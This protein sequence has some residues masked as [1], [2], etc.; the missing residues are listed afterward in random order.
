MEK[1]INSVFV[2][3]WK[4]FVILFQL[5]FPRIC[6]QNNVNRYLRTGRNRRVNS[7]SGFVALGCTVQKVNALIHRLQVTENKRQIA[8]RD[9]HRLDRKNETIDTRSNLRKYQRYQRVDRR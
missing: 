4:V 5:K 7:V 9:P 3:A 6:F 2:L 1:N 8:L